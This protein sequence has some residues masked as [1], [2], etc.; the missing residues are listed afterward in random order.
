MAVLREAFTL[1]ELGEG[2]GARRRAVASITELGFLPVSPALHFTVS[3]VS[4]RRH[5][6]WSLVSM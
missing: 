6:R 4:S 2:P 5:G 3:G 1:E